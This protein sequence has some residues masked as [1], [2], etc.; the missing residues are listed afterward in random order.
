MGSHEY[1]PRQI[2]DLCVTYQYFC[3][4]LYYGSNIS[5]LFDLIS[6]LC[7]GRNNVYYREGGTS[8]S[9][10][11]IYTDIKSFRKG[12]NI[13]HDDV[14][15]SKRPCQ[16]LTHLMNNVFHFYLSTNSQLTSTKRHQLF[17]CEQNQCGWWKNIKERKQMIVPPL[18]SQAL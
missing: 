16:S 6:F 10:L 3:R 14:C 12:W 8:G 5:G 4:D 7:V 18:N 17:R 11:L 13:E 1:F 2:E 15:T 9:G